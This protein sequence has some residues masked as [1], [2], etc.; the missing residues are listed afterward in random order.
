MNLPLFCF[1]SLMDPD[2]LSCVLDA[3]V[4]VR[5]S[6]QPASLP[7]YRKARLPHENYPMLVPDAESVAPGVLITGLNKEE[8]DRIVF[9]EGEEYELAPCQVYSDENEI[10]E[11]LF[12][13][14]GI[15]PPPQS[16]EWDLATW[17]CRSKEYFLRQSTAYMKLYGSMSAAEADV[18]WQNYSE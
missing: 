2:V 17:Q 3:P 5:I 16:E 6:I 12:F 4:P 11:A 8:L 15:M 14:E 18:Y 7:G 9:F 13:D 1:G 10:M